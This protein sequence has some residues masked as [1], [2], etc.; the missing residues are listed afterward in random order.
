MPWRTVGLTMSI[1]GW[2]GH[3]QCSKLVI[4]D[5]EED[6]EN[7]YH[8]LPAHEILTETVV[9][10]DYG[11]HAIRTWILLLQ[12]SVTG[13]SGA[14]HQLLAGDSTPRPNMSDRYLKLGNHS[15]PI[16]KPSDFRTGITKTLSAWG[17]SNRNA[18]FLST[19]NYSPWT[20]K[21][22]RREHSELYRSIK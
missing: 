11:Y 10:C 22:S 15:R 19:R 18:A 9:T 16:W 2:A 5:S 13:T 7:A 14:W 17:Y 3:H 8:I 20:I 4:G 1:E 21:P 6:K 12:K